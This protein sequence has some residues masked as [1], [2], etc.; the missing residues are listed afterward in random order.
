VRHA[1]EQ[2]TRILA[3]ATLAL[4]VT[5]CATV[6]SNDAARD[7]L[8]PRVTAHAAAL[9]SDGGPLSLTTGRAL[10]ATYDSVFGGE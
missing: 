1:R 2:T 3:L 6:A 4:T 8:A 10:I 7:V 5:G 9:A